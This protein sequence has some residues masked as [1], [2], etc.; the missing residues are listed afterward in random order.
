MFFNNAAQG[1]SFYPV[2]SGFNYVGK[3]GLDE[4]ITFIGRWVHLYIFFFYFLLILLFLPFLLIH[5]FIYSKDY[6]M[7]YF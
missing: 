2:S 4:G 5:A 3:A 6:C 1:N 7:S